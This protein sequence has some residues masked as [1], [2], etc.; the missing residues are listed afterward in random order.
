MKKFSSKHNFYS[1]AA[2]RSC[3]IQ[4]SKQFS[5]PK[6]LRHQEKHALVPGII[7]LDL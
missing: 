3:A 2:F 7:N 4:Q 5:F 1:F 6:A